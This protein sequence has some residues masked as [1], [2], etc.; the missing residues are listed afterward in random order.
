MTLLP[1]L[2]HDG[3]PDGPSTAVAGRTVGATE[4]AGK[5]SGAR[6]I[7]QP[8]LLEPATEE[9][10]ERCAR[11]GDDDNELRRR[12]DS[13]KDPGCDWS[14]VLTE[15]KRG[16][17]AGN[18]FGRQGNAHGFGEVP[19]PATPYQRPMP[20]AGGRRGRRGTRRLQAGFYAANKESVM[21]TILIVVLLPLGFGA[22]AYLLWKLLEAAGA[23]SV[24]D[25]DLPE[26]R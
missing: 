12:L 4:C 22:T 11:R 19:D 10:T 16:R 13:S 17:D 3:S 6:K 1:F 15:A 25:F 2:E 20:R 7:G 21:S 18:C 23:T 26:R 8:I 5:G 9:L 24:T 14:G